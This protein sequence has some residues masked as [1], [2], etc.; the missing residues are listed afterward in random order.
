MRSMCEMYWRSTRLGASPPRNHGP[1]VERS[2]ASTCPIVFSS[3]F[4]CASKMPL[5]GRKVSVH[6][7]RKSCRSRLSS[8]LAFAKSSEP[9]G[10]SIGGSR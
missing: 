9:L 3:A 10:G 6:Q 7:S 8:A 5:P 2:A 1:A 4:S